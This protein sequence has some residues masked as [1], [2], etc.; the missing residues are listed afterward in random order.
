MKEKA[1]CIVRY[2]ERM[3]SFAPDNNKEVYYDL[4][5]LLESSHLLEYIHPN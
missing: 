5:I 2:P 1:D 4:I 3:L